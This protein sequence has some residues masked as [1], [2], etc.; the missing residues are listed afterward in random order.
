MVGNRGERF[1]TN[2]DEGAKPPVDVVIG[3]SAEDA[4][5]GDC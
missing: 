1:G 2:A 5:S 4:A 3:H